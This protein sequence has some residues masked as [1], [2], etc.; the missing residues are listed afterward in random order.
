[1]EMEGKRK[2]ERERGAAYGSGLSYAGIFTYFLPT[3]NQA[4]NDY[5]AN[6]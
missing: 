6:Q 1:M 3:T 4:G 5:N 2:R